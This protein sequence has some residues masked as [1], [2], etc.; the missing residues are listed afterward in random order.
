ML[1][2]KASPKPAFAAIWSAPLIA[3]IAFCC[4]PANTAWAQ[5][6]TTRKPAAPSAAASNTPFAYKQIGSPADEPRNGKVEGPKMLKSGE[7]TDQKLFDDYWNFVISQL[8]WQSNQ[9]DLPKVRTLIKGHLRS[10]KD[11]ARERLVKTLILPFCTK[12]AKGKEFSPPT[13]INAVLTIGELNKVDLVPG[14]PPQVSLPEARQVLLELLD[15]KLPV[16]DMQDALRVAA[17]VGLL[18][19]IERGGITDDRQKKLAISHLQSLLKAEQPPP[20]RDAEVHKWLK[21]LAN[22]VNSG[23][24][25][26]RV[27]TGR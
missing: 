9:G 1:D 22:E 27:A 24:N 23:L 17:M 2:R 3:L 18:N 14:G 25:G 6:P 11:P 10:G 21:R 20:G 5:P 13:R 12:V 7:I 16:D 8:T 15:P 19:H 4:A 26:G